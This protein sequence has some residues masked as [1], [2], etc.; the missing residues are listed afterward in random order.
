MLWRSSPYVAFL[1][2]RIER[3]NSSAASAYASTSRP[4]LPILARNGNGDAVAACLLSGR[5]RT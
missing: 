1:V 4:V 2:C 3:E 5:Q